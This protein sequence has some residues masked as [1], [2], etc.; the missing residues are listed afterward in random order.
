VMF[1]EV[2]HCEIELL[3]VQGCFLTVTVTVTVVVI[4][5]DAGGV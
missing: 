2:S 4:V 3:C 1:V 5:I